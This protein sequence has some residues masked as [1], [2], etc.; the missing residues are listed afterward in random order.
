ML[1]CFR[2]NIC[3]TF[4]SKASTRL[5][6]KMW[7]ISSGFLSDLCFV[8]LPLPT[9][10]TQLAE[11]AFWLLGAPLAHSHPVI[12]LWIFHP[13]PSFLGMLWNGLFPF[14]IL[15]HPHLYFPKW[16]NIRYMSE[17]QSGVTNSHWIMN[18]C[19]LFAK[20]TF[21]FPLFLFPYSFTP[22]LLFFPLQ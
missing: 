15:I 13:A 12:L 6:F 10:W 21:F 1:D 11:V 8:P 3:L 18:D 9:S 16:I 19:Q 22:F 14:K 17:R 2:W 4:V 20:T 5:R 7:N